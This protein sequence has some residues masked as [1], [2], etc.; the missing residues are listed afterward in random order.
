MKTCV[1]C[2]KEKP[3]TDFIKYGTIR[4]SSCDPCRK[5]YQKA[6]NDKIKKAKTKLW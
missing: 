3:K 6:Y 1:K 2:K 5:A 4:H